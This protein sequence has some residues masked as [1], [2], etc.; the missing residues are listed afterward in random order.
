MRRKLLAAIIAI[1]IVM[2]AF[3]VHANLQVH[4]TRQERAESLPGD[5][6]ISDPISNAYSRH[7]EHQADV[8]G[9]EVTHGILPDA[10]QA[11]ADSFQ[12]E[13]ESALADPDPN[14]LNAFLFYDHPPI[15][16][17]VRFCLTYHPWAEGKQPQFVK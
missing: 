5:S 12:V 11:A 17:R 7:I 4:A 6:L 9:L 10:G 13:G 3:V 1:T 14:A 15:S 8:Y 2:T 16:D